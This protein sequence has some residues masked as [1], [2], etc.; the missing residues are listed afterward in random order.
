MRAAPGE[1]HSEVLTC[2]GRGSDCCNSPCWQP[3]LDSHPTTAWGYSPGDF[4]HKQLWLKAAEVIKDFLCDHLRRKVWC[5][6]KLQTGWVFLPLETKSR[7]KIQSWGNKWKLQNVQ[8]MSFPRKWKKK[9]QPK[10]GLSGFPGQ[11]VV[12]LTFVQPKDPVRGYPFFT[13][14]STVWIV[15]RLSPGW[16]RNDAVV[17]S[18]L[19]ETVSDLSTADAFRGSGA[20]RTGWR[21]T[22]ALLLLNK[23]VFPSLPVHILSSIQALGWILQPSFCKGHL[24]SDVNFTLCYFQ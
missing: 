8:I 7:G 10:S 23:R 5:Q 16:L 4:H 19:T 21:A 22:S 9:K 13:D 17:C 2:P 1:A 3:E 20:S 14:S 6:T 18:D 12:A 11:A 24:R 15:S